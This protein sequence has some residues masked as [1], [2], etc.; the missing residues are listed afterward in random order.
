MSFIGAARGY[1]FLFRWRNIRQAR[2]IEMANPRVTRRRG[3]FR[4][5]RKLA[6]FIA[7][8]GKDTRKV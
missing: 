1:R 8:R 4:S 2:E 6:R 3:C 7:L 5:R